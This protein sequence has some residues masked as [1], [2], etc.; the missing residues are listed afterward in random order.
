MS[1]F[2]KQ[3]KNI[4]LTDSERTKIR[5]RLLNYLETNPVR[6]PEEPRHSWQRS[7]IFS[8]LL[9]REGKLSMPALIIALII[10]ISGGASAAA[11]N[12][13]PGDVLH[14]VKIH[15]NERVRA[16]L[17]ASD[18]AKADLA[19][20]LMD[21]RLQETERLAADADL[22]AELRARVEERFD[23]QA[24]RLSALAEKFEAEGRTE[25]SAKFS[26]HL[27]A[28]LSVHDRVLS[29]L[30]EKLQGV[31][32]E[33]L[34]KIR[35]NI[36]AKIKRADGIRVKVETK[37]KTDEQ[38][39]DHPSVNVQAEAAAKA[40]M[41]ATLHK[42]DEVSAFITAKKDS[43]TAES[44]AKA[45]AKLAAARGL[46][47]E[48][49]MKLEAKAYGEAF[50]LFLK[51]HMVAQSAKL[52]LNLEHRLKIDIKANDDDDDAGQNPANE[53]KQRTD[54]D[55]DRND[56]KENNGRN[57]E[58]DKNLLELKLQQDSQAKIEVR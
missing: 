55:Q 44:A 19:L 42:I 22:S 57:D 35:A 47:A 15:V 3:L 37:V 30:E 18:E 9:T 41:E 53:E 54:T 14:P 7:R 12:S 25:L 23:A 26:A 20:K 17:A 32:P 34:E 13:L 10:A 1:N 46:V 45:E 43:V 8:L 24:E 28:M 6:I 48:G 31:N 58:R 16:M 21:T 36:K 29:Q 27:D 38:D 39:K 40:K 56:Q 11:Q 4:R 52:E 5:S 2:F 33:E 49:Q 51:A 50:A